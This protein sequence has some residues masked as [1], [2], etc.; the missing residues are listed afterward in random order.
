VGGLDITSI[1]SFLGG[2]VSGFTLKVV[3]DRSKNKRKTT[4]TQKN[5]VVGRD[6]IGGD[7]NRK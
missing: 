2:L 4:V 1:L 3:I 5:N 6:M 7:V